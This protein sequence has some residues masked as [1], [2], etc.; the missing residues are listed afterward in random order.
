M[1]P[2]RQPGC[3]LDGEA[4]LSDPAGAGQRDEAMGSERI[5]NPR[6]V[7]LA[8]DETRQQLRQVARRCPRGTVEGRVL[9]EDLLVQVGHG[10]GRF[11][12]QLVAETSAEVAVFAKCIGLPPGAV[13]RAHQQPPCSLV[14]R[15]VLADRLDRSRR[16]R[17]PRRQERIDAVELSC[18]SELVQPRNLG[19]EA[20]EVLHALERATAPPVQGCTDHLGGARRIR[21]D[22]ALGVIDLSFEI[23]GIDLVTVGQDEAVPGGRAGDAFLP[24][25]TSQVRHVGVQRRSRSV[26]DIVAPYFGQDLV[27]GQRPPGVDEQQREDRALDR[28]AECHRQLAVEH[29]DRTEHGIPHTRTVGR[30]PQRPPGS[31]GTF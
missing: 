1:E 6:V 27:G 21:T 9:Q 3:D 24:E 15:P 26:V 18:R 19:A 17:R 23:E 14:Q 20:G 13:Q 11:D 12:S 16:R 22:D 4:R 29:S 5:D 2:S 25:Y 8:A 30:R 10:T 7:V 28:S 31:F